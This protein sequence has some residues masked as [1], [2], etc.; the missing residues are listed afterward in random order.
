M[1]IKIKYTVRNKGDRQ[2]K[3]TGRQGGRRK[4]AE[5]QRQI[6]RKGRQGERSRGKQAESPTYK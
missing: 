1:K 2:D 3:E 4:E 6:K 5:G